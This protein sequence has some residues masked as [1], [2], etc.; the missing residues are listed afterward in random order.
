MLLGAAW[1]V[2]LR[3]G[4]I[5]V[6]CARPVSCGF[7]AGGDQL[8]VKQGHERPQGQA[9]WLPNLGAVADATDTPVAEM[10]TIVG[11]K[12][13]IILAEARAR[14]SYNLLG[15][16]RTGGVFNHLYGV[17]AAKLPQRYLL[18]GATLPQA[19]GEAGIVHHPTAADVYA[20]MTVSVARGSEVGPKGRLFAKPE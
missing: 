8:R 12:P 6:E 4:S 20:V 13:V 9:Q 17:A 2:P 16:I 3:T 7:Q 11:Q 19:S 15:G 14:A 18:D 1:A 10:L 5:D